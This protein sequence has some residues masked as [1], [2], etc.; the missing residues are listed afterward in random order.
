MAD[1]NSHVRVPRLCGA[2]IFALV[3]DTK[4]CPSEMTYPE[5]RYTFAVS[6]A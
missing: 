5:C 1:G 4:L 3:A 6:L 2:Y